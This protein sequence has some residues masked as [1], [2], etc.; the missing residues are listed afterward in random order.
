VLERLTTALVLTAIVVPTQAAAQY[1]RPPQRAMP[2]PM[3]HQV[4]ITPW[5]GYAWT[6]S[7]R[8]T[9]LDSTGDL[10]IGSGPAWGVEVDVNLHAGAQLALSYSRQDSKFS[11]KSSGVKTD[12]SDLSVEYFQIGGIG[13]VR[14]GKVLPFGM[15]TLGAS[16]FAFKDIRA[17]DDLWKFS[18]VLGLGAK[19]YASERIGLRVQATLPWTM[20]SGGAGIGCGYGGCYTTVGGVG[21]AQFLAT[22]GLMFM[23]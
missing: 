14:Q 4:E 12:V 1:R 3:M 16:R 11:Y 6:I 10:D 19:V 9:Y 15:V 18:I 22:A 23:F 21:V 5:A 20:M 7:R 17:A 8:V 13:G 2:Q